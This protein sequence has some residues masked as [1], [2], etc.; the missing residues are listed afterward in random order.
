MS[1]GTDDCVIVCV[2]GF[3]RGWLCVCGWFCA[4]LAL[5]F[6]GASQLRVINIII[7]IIIIIVGRLFE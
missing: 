7:I 5:L 3:V 1:D 6:F 4:G 2:V